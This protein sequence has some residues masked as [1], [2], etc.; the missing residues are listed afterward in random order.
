MRLPLL[1]A[2]ALAS[3]CMA[4]SPG[5]PPSKHPMADAVNGT[6]CK[7][8]YPTGS[9]ISRRVCREPPS[10]DEQAETVMLRNAWPD[11]PFRAGSYATDT[12]GLRVYR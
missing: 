6:V 1:A 12:P 11:N 5:G 9:N 2:F 7:D 3:G 4:E 10:P 8:E